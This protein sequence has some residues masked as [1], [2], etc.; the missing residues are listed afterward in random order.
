MRLAWLAR[1]IFNALWTK[2]RRV[3][4]RAQVSSHTLSES[5][6]ANNGA[7]E[8]AVDDFALAVNAAE[9]ADTGFVKSSQPAYQSP[10]CF[11]LDGITAAAMH[12]PPDDADNAGATFGWEQ[13]H[14]IG[15]AIG[16]DV[17]D[18]LAW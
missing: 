4:L 18:D 13:V 11:L 3:M 14:A 1:T 7:A 12:L 9:R 8:A 16:Q 15:C 10:N 5:A 17:I 6:S 2:S